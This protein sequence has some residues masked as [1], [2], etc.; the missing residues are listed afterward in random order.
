M[1]TKMSPLDVAVELRR[2]AKRLREL[3]A[4]ADEH[5]NGSHFAASLRG[6]ARGV[7]EAAT[8][9]ENKLL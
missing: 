5:E 3:A 4:K 1:M 9:V 6:R 7:D 2:R 8:M